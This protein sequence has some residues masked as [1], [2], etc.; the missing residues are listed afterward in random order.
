MKQNKKPKQT[1]ESAQYGLEINFKHVENPNQSSHFS[2]RSKLR[3]KLDLSL[4]K[5]VEFEMSGSTR[6]FSCNGKI[7]IER[8]R[9]V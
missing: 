9:E 7:K 2:D 1:L 3:N 6:Q 5:H 4:L 8:D